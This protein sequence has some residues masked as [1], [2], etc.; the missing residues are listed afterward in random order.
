MRLS[1]SASV[2]PVKFVYILIKLSI[3]VLLSYAVGF[4]YLRARSYVVLFWR[5]FI[6]AV[7]YFGGVLT[8]V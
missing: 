8:P 2:H 6:L 4:I 3:G 7:C 5:C 1:S